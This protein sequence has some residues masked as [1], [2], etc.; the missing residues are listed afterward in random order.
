MSL[1]DPEISNSCYESN[2]LRCVHIGLLCVQEHAKDRPTMPTVVSMLA[3]EIVN[4]PPPRKVAFVLRHHLSS[5]ESSSRENKINSNNN[6]T[7]TE[8]QG[9]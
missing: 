1:I 3:S 7:I 6:V 4:L 9:R 5:S 8:I 2:I